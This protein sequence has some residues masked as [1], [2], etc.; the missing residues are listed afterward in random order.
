[1]PLL[2]V[3]LRLQRLALQGSVIMPTT[4]IASEDAS[5]VRSWLAL[6]VAI[7]VGSLADG[8]Q[9]AMQPPV[10][11]QLAKAPAVGG[12]PRPRRRPVESGVPPETSVDRGGTRRRAGRS[13]TRNGRGG[14]GR[15]EKSWS[16]SPSLSTSPASKT[17][18]PPSDGPAHT[19]S[20]ERAARPA[21]GIGKQPSS[22]PRGTSVRTGPPQKACLRTR[23]RNR[24]GS[25]RRTS[26]VE[27]LPERR[28]RAPKHPPVAPEGSV[29]CTHAPERGSPIGC[30]PWSRMA[31][32]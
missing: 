21:R 18:P 6:P 1:M 3:G 26:N 24:V 28:A 25:A 20:A 22:D 23:R 15:A 7:E 10:R 19:P 12:R 29:L 16:T 9:S 27:H 11:L 30:T 5:I 17:S 4:C 32:P 31:R 8:E 13:R 2:V 14:G